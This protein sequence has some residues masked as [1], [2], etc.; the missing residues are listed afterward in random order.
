[1]LIIIW[2][3]L[4]LY[5]QIPIEVIIVPKYIGCLEYLYIPDVIKDPFLTGEIKGVKFLPSF[6]IEIAIIDKPIQVMK[7]AVYV[8]KFNFRN[9]SNLG[10]TTFGLKIFQH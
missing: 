6:I 8:M 7:S 1:M 4:N 9:S 2:I 3:K 10:K 5:K